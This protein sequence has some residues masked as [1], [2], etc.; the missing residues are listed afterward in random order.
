MKGVDLSGR[1]EY[2]VRR[3]FERIGGAIDFALRR[4]GAIEG[5]SRADL[6][7][8]APLIEQAVEE[9]LKREDSRVVA[10]NLIELRYD[11]ETYTRMGAPRRE[12]LQRELSASIYE[13]IYNRR[14][15]TLS[16]VQVRIAYDAFTRGL[17]IRTGFGEAMPAVIP[18]NAP[19]GATRAARSMT[20]APNAS[21]SRNVV[22]RLEDGSRELGASVTSNAEPVGIGRNSANSLIVNDPSVSNF[23]AALTFSADGSLFLADRGSSNGTF[24]NGVALEPGGRCIVRDGDRLKFGDIEATLK[25]I[26]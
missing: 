10:P 14:Y 18:Q 20:A 19:E 25:V 1:L 7:T 22:L 3:L 24:V 8:L 13:Y 5:G 12:F 21:I 4:G 2:F 23:H 15:D 6:A 26:V 11:Y 16:E 9:N 17:E